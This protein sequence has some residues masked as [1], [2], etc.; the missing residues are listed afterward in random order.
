[1]RNGK[2]K[3]KKIWIN[4]NVIIWLIKMIK[5]NEWNNKYGVF[6]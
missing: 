4:K 2:S 1:M 3:N 5:S 6:E